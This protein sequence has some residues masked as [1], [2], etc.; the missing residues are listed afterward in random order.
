MLGN[1]GL[2]IHQF[3]SKRWGYVGNVP[4]ALG[5]TV[6][7]DT[8]AVLGCRAWRDESGALVMTKFPSFETCGEAVQHAQTCGFAPM[9]NN[10]PQVVEA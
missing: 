3:P 10:V 2:H 5:S 6:P 7:A 1:L 4:R 8:A 9:V